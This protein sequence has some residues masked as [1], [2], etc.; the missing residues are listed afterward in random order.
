MLKTHFC[1]RGL[2][3]SGAAVLNAR[4]LLSIA[5]LHFPILSFPCYDFFLNECIRTV[6]YDGVFYFKLNFNSQVHFEYL[7]LLLPSCALR[8]VSRWIH[9]VLTPA[10]SGQHQRNS[11]IQ[12]VFKSHSAALWKIERIETLHNVLRRVVQG[13]IES[14]ENAKQSEIKL[15]DS[16]SWFCAMSVRDDD[17]IKWTEKVLLNC[18]HYKLAA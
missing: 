7:V 8:E 14:W 2:N 11:K 1:S 4:R 18:R 17:T 3:I 12:Q 5:I 15:S 6:K 13:N 10:C 16:S 9:V